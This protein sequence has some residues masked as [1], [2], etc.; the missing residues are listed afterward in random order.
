MP[1]DPKNGCD[2]SK[3]GAETAGCVS[4]CF[5]G[6]TPDLLTAKEVPELDLII[7]GGTYDM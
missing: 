7:G 4:P 6:Y 5:A 2:P 1:L 3:A